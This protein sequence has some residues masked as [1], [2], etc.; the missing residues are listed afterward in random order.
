M[1]RNNGSFRNIIVGF[2]GSTDSS[3]AV[4][5][6]CSIA[7]KYDSRLTVIHVYKSPSTVFAP[8]PGMPVPDFAELERAAE[9]VG[10]G[11]LAKGIELA[12]RSGVKAKGELMEGTSAVE[13]IVTFASQEKADLIVVGTRGMTGFKKLVLGSVSAGLVGHANCPVLVVR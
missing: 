1:P 3:K 12:T 7:T 8:G 2:D 5:V 11:V 9:E 4:R 6:A 10:K 13:A